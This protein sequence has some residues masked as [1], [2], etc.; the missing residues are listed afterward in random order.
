MKKVFIFAIAALLS[1]AAGM[2]YRSVGDIV[3][4]AWGAGKQLA[5]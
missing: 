3:G 4:Q 5:E 1:D 2:C